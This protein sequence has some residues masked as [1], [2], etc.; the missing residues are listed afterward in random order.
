MSGGVGGAG[1]PR[2]SSGE[3][4]GKMVDS[5]GWWRH[6][7]AR[8]GAP[9]APHGGQRGAGIATRGRRRSRTVFV[10]VHDRQLDDKGRCA[11]PSSFR[12]DL[13]DR[14][15]LSLGDDGYVTLRTV[16]RF[17]AHAQELIE[18]Q[19]RGEISLAR[20]RSIAA[21]SVSVA[22]DKQGRLTLDERFR[23]HAGLTPGSPVV[24]AGNLDTIEIWKPER[25][26]AIEAEG[27]DE[28]PTRDWG[29]L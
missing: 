6:N 20:R 27:H 23:N 8:G 14:V 2:G 5:G 13:G 7:A 28:G 15:Y 16:E 29:D 3:K 24:V 19:K 18:A 25:F 4:W 21:S 9:T 17:E 12:H 10:G 22:V 1:A 26:H 11:L